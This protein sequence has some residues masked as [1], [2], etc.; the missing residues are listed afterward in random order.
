M[1]RLA[2]VIV[3]YNSEADIF[4]CIKSVK[5]HSD[6]PEGELELIVVDNNSRSADAMFAR[7]KRLWG[8]DITLIKNASNDGYGQGN[9][10]GIRAATAPVVM[11]MNPDVRLCEPV[12]SRAVSRF[13]G[14]DGLGALGMVQMFSETRRS[15]RS[16]YP[17]WFVNGW[18]RILLYAFC[19]RIDWYLPKYMYIHGSCFFVRREMFLAAG[20]FDETNFLYGEEEDLHYRMKR[21]FGA[22]CFAFE[23]TL[24]Y[25]HLASERRPSADYERRLF[26]VNAALYAKKGIS[27]RVM[28]RRFLQSNR[29]LLWIK[30]LTG[31]RGE[32]YKVLKEF[33]EYLL[34]ERAK[35]SK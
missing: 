16:F 7:I 14:N 20:G 6:L 8:E 21:L 28:L 23:R 3:T 17:T 35:I 25:I 31:K 9:N 29:M 24:H 34:A 19:N 1:K 12:F 30:S 22:R 18:L 4:D 10:V 32:G 15:N 13:E 26:E 33:R 27:R 2:I 5:T 11:I